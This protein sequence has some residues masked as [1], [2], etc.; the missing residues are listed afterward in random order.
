[1]TNLTLTIRT[2]RK[3]AQAMTKI[4]PPNRTIKAHFLSGLS[5]AF[6][7]KG[8]GMESRYVSVATFKAK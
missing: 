6:H 1:M 4:P 5:L 8:S 7:N 2:Q 3:V